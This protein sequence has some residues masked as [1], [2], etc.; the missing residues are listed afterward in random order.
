MT[1]MTA[2]MT[3][4]TVQTLDMTTVVYYAIDI[5]RQSSFLCGKICMNY[6]GHVCTQKGNV[7]KRATEF[8]VGRRGVS[9][10]MHPPNPTPP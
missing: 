8:G 9:N 1:A 7:R 3:A 5:H 10:Q 6:R 2:M 4:T